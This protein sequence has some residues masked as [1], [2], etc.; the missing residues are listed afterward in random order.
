M[1]SQSLFP[2]SRSE[3][4]SFD[5]VDDAAASRSA[6][7]WPGVRPLQPR[8]AC[9]HHHQ[10]LVAVAIGTY[11]VGQPLSLFRFSSASLVHRNTMF[12]CTS[13]EDNINITEKIASPPSPPLLH[14]SLSISP[15]I[16][17]SGFDLVDDL[18]F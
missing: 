6:P 1:I 16:L 7:C 8:A 11:I 17:R 14:L 9:F 4:S 3:F 12:V 5:G 10:A 2:L 18:G 13:M 15:S